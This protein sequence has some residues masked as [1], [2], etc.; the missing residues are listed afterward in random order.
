MLPKKEGVQGMKGLPVCNEDDGDDGDLQ[1]QSMR[2]P[3]QTSSQTPLSSMPKPV[4]VE[5]PRFK[6]EYGI[7]PMKDALMTMDVKAPFVP[8]GHFKRMTDDE[9]EEDRGSRSRRR[10][11]KREGRQECCRARITSS[12]H[13]MDVYHKAVIEVNE[14][15]TEAAAATAVAMTRSLVMPVDLKVEEI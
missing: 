6:I 10:M 14:E 3:H 9:R 1:K 5:L 4:I 7:K 8:G 12:V 13:I 2:S 15:G 11:D